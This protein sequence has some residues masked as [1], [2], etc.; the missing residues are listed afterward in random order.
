MVVRGHGIAIVTAT[1]GQTEIGKI[2]HDLGRPKSES[3]NLEKETAKL[4]RVFGFVSMLVCA[5]VASRYG[6]LRGN[7]IKGGSRRWRLAIAML[8][9]EFP[10]VLTIFMALGAWRISRKKVLT[11]RFPAIEMLGAATVICVDKTGT[12][13]ENRMTV[14][15]V[16][17]HAPMRG[18]G[19]S[20]R[21]SARGGGAGV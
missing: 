8:P 15:E 13:T 12:L 16:F 21:P 10:V 3:S 7:W 19:T 11:R 17:A 5:V 18:T 20:S 6:L 9:E 14:R 4:V 1:G 2:G